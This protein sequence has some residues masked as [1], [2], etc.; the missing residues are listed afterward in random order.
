MHIKL[1]VQAKCVL[2]YFLGGII[3]LHT[4]ASTVNPFK[5]LVTH[6]SFCVEVYGIHTKLKNDYS[7]NIFV[8]K[9]AYGFVEQ[10]KEDT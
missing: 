9:S 3:S 7:F 8:L 2:L 4:Q 1:I 6:F 10:A 5:S